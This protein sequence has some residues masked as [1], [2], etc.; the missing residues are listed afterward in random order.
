MS[1][2]PF[3][4]RHLSSDELEDSIRNERDRRVLERLIFIRCLYDGEGVAKATRKLGRSKVAGYEWLKRWNDGG[5]EELKPTFRGGRPSKLSTDQQTELK[6]KLEQRRDWTTKEVGRL[7]EE[8]FGVAYSLRSMRRILRSLKMRFAKPY[9]RDYRRPIDAEAKLKSTL[10]DAL[11]KL[12]DLEAEDDFV[13]GFLDEC[14]P[15]T[16][17]N[18]VRRWAF[19]KPMVVKDT[20]KYKANTFG[21]YALGGV[22]VMEFL[23]NSKK[24]NV[25][26]FLE[27]VRANNPNRVLLLFLD[28][29][30]SHTA[31]A[32]KQKAEE[33]GIT[34]VY[35]PPYSPDLNPIEQLWRCLRREI[36]TAFFRSREEFLTLIES[37]YRQLAP[38]ISFAKGWILKFLPQKF[39]QLCPQL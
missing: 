21:F 37:A 29:L 27:E 7:I 34:L 17:A 35:L 16:E 25:C 8:D 6:Q 23:E 3:V 28:N 11:G 36:S 22:S 1:R 10:D 19:E 9:P 30:R 5:L 26:R 14:S 2:V 13:V 18:T 39:N 24:E 38:R 4:K 31:Q 32:T 20:T 12:D 15:Q 33:L